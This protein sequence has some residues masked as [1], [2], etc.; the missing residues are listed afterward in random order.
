MGAPLSTRIL[1]PQVPGG[2]EYEQRLH[3]EITIDEEEENVAL[4]DSG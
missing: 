1:A 4:H 3:T 2:D